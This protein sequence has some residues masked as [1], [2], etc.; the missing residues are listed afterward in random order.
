MTPI[1][2]R[3]LARDIDDLNDE[4]DFLFRAYYRSHSPMK[5]SF[6]QGWKPATDVY[7]TD[8]EIVI[9]MDIAGISTKDI[10]LQLNDNVLVLSGLRREIAGVKRKYH[11]MEIDFGP[12][13]RRIELPAP[14]DP[15]RVTARY[16]QGF[17]EVRLPKVD[18][19]CPVSCTIEV[20]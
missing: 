14:V 16:L 9:L 7:E 6:N 3:Y 2:P 19:V 20:K 15:E 5:M 13:E 18:G 10:T 11:A 8:S 12:F 1:R 4:L 17:L